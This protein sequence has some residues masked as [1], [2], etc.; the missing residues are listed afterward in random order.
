M[1]K[2]LGPAARLSAIVGP[3]C[4]RTLYPEIGEFL[5][6]PDA[7][8]LGELSR[9]GLGGDDHAEFSLEIEGLEAGAACIEVGHDLGPLCPVQFLIEECVDLGQGPFAVRCP[10]NWLRGRGSW[11]FSGGLGDGIGQSPL[12][13]KVM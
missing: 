9:M 13:G 4:A 6:N 5:F 12:N 7:K 10:G 8:R 2:I 1:R 11:R 3:N